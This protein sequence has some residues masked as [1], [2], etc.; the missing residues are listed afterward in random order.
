M[1]ELLTLYTH[2][3]HMND[4]AYNVDG[5]IEQIRTENQP[6]FSADLRDL[7]MS[8][9]KPNA[10]DRIS[11]HPLRALITSYRERI[12]E[13]YNNLSDDD[14]RAKFEFE[15]LLFYVKDEINNM[16]TGSWIPYDPEP[17]PGIEKFPDTWP[18]KY[19]RFDKGREGGRGGSEDSEGSDEDSDE[20][21][22]SD[23]D[24]D[25]DVGR[26]R[27]QEPEPQTAP[28]HPRDWPVGFSSH[29]GGARDGSLSDG[30]RPST[31][32]L[33]NETCAVS[34]RAASEDGGME[35]REDSLTDRLVDGSSYEGTGDESQDVGSES[36]YPGSPPRSTHQVSAPQALA[37]DPQPAPRRLRNGKAFAYFEGMDRDLAI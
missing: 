13:R 21:E 27:A 24:D 33:L 23:D 6:E 1:L 14:G 31:G 32:A 30:R 3:E 22:D 37:A 28:P 19:P 29:D 7:I 11:L 36:D 16:P 35:E 12:H 5:V 8:C 17:T 2:A 9:I 4:P 34:G 25:D 26:T 20:D 18:I 10:S 15:N